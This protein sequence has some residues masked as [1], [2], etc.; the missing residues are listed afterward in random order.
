MKN[1]LLAPLLPR[2]IR[3]WR[4]FGNNNGPAKLAHVEDM[5]ARHNIKLDFDTLNAMVDAE[6]KKMEQAEGVGNKTE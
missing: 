6:I 5:L 4:R 3:R 2:F 1:P